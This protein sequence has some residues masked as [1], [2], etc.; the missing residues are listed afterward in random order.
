MTNRIPSPDVEIDAENTDGRVRIFITAGDLN[1]TIGLD[2]DQAEAFVDAL[3]WRVEGA[4]AAAREDA[5]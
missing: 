5:E 3:T 2:P 1:V 4:V